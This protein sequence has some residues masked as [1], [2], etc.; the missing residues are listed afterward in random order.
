MFS[1]L[2]FPQLLEKAEAREREREKEEARKMKRKESAFKSMLKQATPPIEL[3]AVWEDVR[4]RIPWEKK[5]QIPLLIPK[6]PRVRQALPGSAAGTSKSQQ[7]LW[8]LQ[9]KIGVG[10]EKLHLD[11]FE[12]K[13]ILKEV[14]KKKSKVT[15]P[16]K[17][18]HS[19]PKLIEII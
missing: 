1:I 9:E 3:D 11:S 17:K 6:K 19:S 8:F 15:P 16:T 4:R 18:S 13:K 7:I 2:F 14:G 10:W 5:S 12:V